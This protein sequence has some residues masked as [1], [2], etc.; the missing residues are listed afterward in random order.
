MRQHLEKNIK[1]NSIKKL[2]RLMAMRMS[3]FYFSSLTTCY[4]QFTKIVTIG[5]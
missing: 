3:I 4:Y 1:V 2:M 5:R